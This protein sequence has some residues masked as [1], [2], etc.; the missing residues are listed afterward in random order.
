MSAVLL[1]VHAGSDPF[2][3]VIA[4]FLICIGGTYAVTGI[5]IGKVLARQSEQR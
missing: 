2:I 1:V 4:V 3:P 5:I